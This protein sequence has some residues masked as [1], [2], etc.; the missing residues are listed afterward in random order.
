MTRLD[1]WLISRELLPLLPR[2]WMAQLALDDGQ[3]ESLVG[4]ASDLG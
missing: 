3:S 1:R 4:R 2:F